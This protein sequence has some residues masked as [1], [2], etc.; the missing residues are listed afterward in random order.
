MWLITNMARKNK[1][2]ELNINKRDFNPSN[3]EDRILAYKFLES[4]TWRSITTDNLCP[5]FCEWPYIEVPAM[6][7]DKLV[8]YY[9]SKE[10]F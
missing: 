6:L 5:F 10:R 7:K 3:R 1:L 4:Y 2:S 8:E 9:K